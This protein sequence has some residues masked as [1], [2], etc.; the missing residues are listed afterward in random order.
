MKTLTVIFSGNN[1]D[2]NNPN[3]NYRDIESL[4]R[5]LESITKTFAMYS[6]M[7]DTNGEMLFINIDK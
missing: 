6:P 3:A 2:K 4:K 7:Y 1:H 5:T